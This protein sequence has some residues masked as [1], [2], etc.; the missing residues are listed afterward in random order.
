MKDGFER[1]SLTMA[2]MLVAEAMGTREAT[3]Y[4]QAPGV[5]A[6]IEW[7]LPNGDTLRL[8]ADAQTGLAVYLKKGHDNEL[9]RSFGRSVASSV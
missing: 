5:P 6:F 7:P 1:K 8:V 9:G 4:I 2:A 3:A